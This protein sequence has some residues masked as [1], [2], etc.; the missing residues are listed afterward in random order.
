[1]AQEKGRILYKKIRYSKERVE[2]IWV[3][4]IEENFINGSIDSFIEPMD[5][6]KLAMAALASDC[7]DICELDNDDLIKRCEVHTVNI[8]YETEREIPGII[9]SFKIN[10]ENRSGS[11][12]INTPYH[13]LKQR[14][15]GSDEQVLEG[16]T[17]EK[18][19]TLIQ[20]AEQ[21]RTG[22]KKQIVFNFNP[23]ENTKE[24]GFIVKLEMEQK[25]LIKPGVLISLN[26]LVNESSLCKQ[27]GKSGVYHLNPS[28]DKVIN[29]DKKE[30]DLFTFKRN[31]NVLILQSIKEMNIDEYK[32]DELN[33]TMIE[34][35]SEY[36]AEEIK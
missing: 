34:L 10:R 25:G 7:I 2:L 19:N 23:E 32:K 9:L 30:I 4:K 24:D 1:M 16:E 14:K 21:Y 31:G 5:S 12:S 13:L 29:D 15:E 36:F 20:E 27:N 8:R 3:E 22:K 6:F 33:K 28:K 35:I 18:I 17:A 11:I 26:K